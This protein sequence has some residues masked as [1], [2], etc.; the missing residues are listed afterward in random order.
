MPSC[1]GA[2]PVWIMPLNKVVESFNPVENRFDIVIIDEASQSDV[3]ALTALYLGEKAII[4][5]DNEQ[6]SP[7]SIG[8]R[9]E[10]MDRLIREYL[11]DI[12]TI[13][14]IQVILLI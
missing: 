6:V 12:L 5:G 9:T 11:Y 8:E 3:M 1:Q 4:V 7:L 10:D 14:S 2:I 13:S